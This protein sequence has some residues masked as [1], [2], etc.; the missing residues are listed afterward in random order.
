[1]D[2]SRGE[3]WWVTS[4]VTRAIVNI[5]MAWSLQRGKTEG[6]KSIVSKVIYGRRGVYQFASGR[7]ER[8]WNARLPPPPPPPPPRYL[9]HVPS[10]SPLSLPLCSRSSNRHR[11]LVHQL[12][13]IQEQTTI[14]YA[15]SLS[16]PISQTA[17]DYLSIRERKERRIERER[18]RKDETSSRL[19]TIKTTPSLEL[20]RRN[21]RQPN[22]KVD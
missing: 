9:H 12:L 20:D 15:L 2:K 19:L 11:L 8:A 4:C 16:L 6:T 10:S 18:E 13:D 21:D 5:R 14:T 22:S 3:W 7:C 17:F 1:M